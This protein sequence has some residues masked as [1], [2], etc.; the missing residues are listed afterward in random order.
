MLFLILLCIVFY[1]LSK[2][3]IILSICGDSMHPTLKD[4]E[5][6]LAMRIF[7]TSTFSFPA[8]RVRKVY[9]VK[10]PQSCINEH[11]WVIKRLMHIDCHGTFDSGFYTN[12][13][14][15]FIEGDNKNNSYDSRDFGNI[16]IECLKYQLLFK[17]WGGKKN[18]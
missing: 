12:I 17:V 10:L 18:D 8:V 1:I 3:F 13:Y 5:Y 7:H 4:G 14:S 15:A 2:M 11:E 16:P 6:Y 9:A